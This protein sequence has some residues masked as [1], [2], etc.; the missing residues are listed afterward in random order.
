[1]NEINFEPNKMKLKPRKLNRK[2]GNRNVPNQ[3]QRRIRTA[4]RK[5]KAEPKIS[6]TPTQNMNNKREERKEK[7]I[8]HEDGCMMNDHATRSMVAPR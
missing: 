4:A 8:A 3:T 7:R 6:R 2:A 5:L 1:M